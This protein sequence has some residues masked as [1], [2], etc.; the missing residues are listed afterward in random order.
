MCIF[1]QI[2]RKEIAAQIVYEDDKIL[3]FKDIQPKAPLHLLL[4]PKKHFV[5]LNQVKKEGEFLLGHL[6]YQAKCLAQEFKIAKD[7]YKIV[8]NCGQNGGQMVEHLHLHLLGGEKLLGF[9]V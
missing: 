5:S 1:C 8:I 2:I 4:V 9:A 6:L 7:G 3:A